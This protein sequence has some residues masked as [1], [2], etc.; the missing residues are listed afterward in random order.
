MIQ[1]RNILLVDNDD[2]NNFIN[3]SIINSS[4]EVRFKRI[5]EFLNGE[6]ALLFL[7][8]T[9]GVLN[10]LDLIILDINMPR[11]DGFEFLEA[12]PRLNSVFDTANIPVMVLSSSAK[13]KDKIKSL[14]FSNVKGYVS[15]PLTT[16]ILNDFIRQNILITR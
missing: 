2:I 9:R 16:V 7:A 14:N 8:G 5:L 3:R 1:L 10:N 13:S 15:K 4:E 12:L 11:M 6:D